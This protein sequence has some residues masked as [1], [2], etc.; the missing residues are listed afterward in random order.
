MSCT[1]LF[2]A[3]FL[4][5]DIHL[6]SS[7][8]G[9]W[10]LVGWRWWGN[11]FVFT[12]RWRLFFWGLWYTWPFCLFWLTFYWVRWVGFRVRTFSVLSFWGAACL[13]VFL[14]RVTV[15]FRPCCWCPVFWYR[16]YRFSRCRFRF[17]RY[18]FRFSRCRFFATISVYR[19]FFSGLSFYWLLRL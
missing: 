10:G 18:R 11:Y 14:F 15:G 7:V 17:S 3:Y 4:S 13:V 12:W 8:S 16:R 9:S 19:G 1:C 6:G 5:A 2:A